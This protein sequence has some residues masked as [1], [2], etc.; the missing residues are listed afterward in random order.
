[1]TTTSNSP[2]ATSSPGSPGS[3]GSPAG[4][5]ASSGAVPV[6][7]AEPGIG[8]DFRAAA[9]VWRR[10]LIR[11]RTDRTRIIALLIQPVLFLF[12][13]G[14][15]LASLTAG[16]TFGIELKTFMFPGVLATSTLFTA[17][18]AA[19]SV[20]WDREFGFLREMMVA[21]VSRSSIMVGKCIGGTTVATLQG[22]LVIAL[23]PLVHVPLSVPL[24]AELIGEVF[25]ISFAITALGLVIAAR[26][27]QMQ[28][29]MGIM[30]MIM[31]PMM[32]LSGALYPL[33]D[34]PKWL[35]VL[36]HL[37]PLTYGVHA[38]RTTVFNHIN[39]SP[40]A[41]AALNPPLSIGGWVVPMAAQLGLIL[42]IG[43]VL[44]T[45][46]S[47]EFSRSE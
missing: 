8:H 22:C 39:A 21:P 17:M 27:K 29:V 30:Q 45:V 46:A 12:V 47:S 42:V 5:G 33:G 6:R 16:S 41:M 11:F 36:V 24:V 13:L 44:L 28:A 34:L 4:S 35:S 14:N 26:I 20:V 31:L 15:G 43:L 1:M 7:V 3:P 37:N 40:E 23:A 38:V 25:L 9:I 2:S 19:I 10:E 32:M 18:F